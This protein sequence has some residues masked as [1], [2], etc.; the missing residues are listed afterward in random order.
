[1]EDEKEVK[2]PSHYTTLSIQKK[3]NDE[4]EK[5]CKKHRTKKADFVRLSL[6]YFKRNGID[7]NTENIPQTEMQRINKRVEQFFSFLV[8]QE[9]EILKPIYAAVHKQKQETPGQGDKLERYIATLNKNIIS[10]A[11]QEKANT[12]KL[13][14]IIQQQSAQIQ[15]YSAAIEQLQE[16]QKAILEELRTKKKGGLFS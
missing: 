8:T 3:D 13:R 14:Q 16:T 10:L 6:A 2:A 7:P 11:E 15:I 9:R 12:D 5:W 1:M 4:L